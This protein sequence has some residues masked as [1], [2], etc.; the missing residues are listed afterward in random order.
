M[1]GRMSSTKRLA[2][3]VAATLAGF[4]V[5]MLLTSAPLA[6]GPSRKAVAAC[7]AAPEADCALDLGFALLP[8]G[9]R[10]SHDDWVAAF[11]AAGKLDAVRDLLVGQAIRAGAT[12]EAAIAEVRGQLAW[13]YLAR[14]LDNGQTLAE[15]IA[16]L[17]EADGTD[18]SFAAD[19]VLGWSPDGWRALG[20]REIPG[21]EDR[22]TAEEIAALFLAWTEED[23]DRVRVFQMEDLVNL[24]A[25]L[26]DRE[27]V[28]EALRVARSRGADLRGVYDDAYRVA[29]PEA[30]LDGVDLADRVNAI[31]LERAG[32]AEPDDAKAQAYLARAFEVH[33]TREIWPDYR[34]MRGVVWR[35]TE[36]GLVADAIAYARRMAELAGS[37]R[38]N[39]FRAFGHLDAAAALLDAGAGHDEVRAELEQA[40][41]LFP[42]RPDA[43]VAVGLVSGPMRWEAFGL[44]DEARGQSAEIL[45]RMG[46]LDSAVAVLATSRVPRDVWL[47]LTMIELPPSQRDGFIAAAFATLPSEEAQSFAAQL[48]SR[49]WTELWA[50]VTAD[51][52]E[53]ETGD[54]EAW[55]APLALALAEVWYEAGDMDRG[56]A[57]LERA[58][59]AALEARDGRLLL[60]TGGLMA[61]RP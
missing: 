26:G 4:G 47:G 12:Q 2:L 24:Y 55:G 40:W 25:A 54:A 53:R 56:K 31:V 18:L 43:V 32:S 29:G 17:P 1:T 28:L 58:A 10:Q 11:D 30:V 48:L 50:P 44:G 46:D 38:E 19:R 45:L 15:A 23:P 59:R 37:D 22:A 20:P 49:N 41:R 27:G 9:Q 51:L 39:P 8:E 34:A 57:A 7:H 60:R 14:A 21:P 16:S 35:A 3:L 6:K 13:R 33:A 5:V 36:R 52:V 42:D 61:S